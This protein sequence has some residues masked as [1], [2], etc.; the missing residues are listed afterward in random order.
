MSTVGPSNHNGLNIDPTNLY[1]ANLSLDFSQQELEQYFGEYG[2][3]VGSRVL[4]DKVTGASRGVAFVRF[5]NPESAKAAMTALNGT[6]A[7]RADRPL[8]V[9]N[10]QK[11]SGHGHKSAQHYDAFAAVPGNAMP[12]PQ[13]AL[14]NP[15]GAPAQPQQ[16]QYA[17][18]YADPFQQ[19]QP[20]YSTP[21]HQPGMSLTNCYI[22]GLPVEYGQ[23]ELNVLFAPYG[24]IIGSRVLMNNETSESRGIAFV[25]LD[26]HANATRAIQALNG[27]VIFFGQAPV[28]VTYAKE[29]EN[30]KGAKAVPGFAAPAYAPV[31][32]ETA[33]ARYAPYA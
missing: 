24:K 5:D 28:T 13:A 1:I 6:V 15:Y 10:A 27:S 4:S 9:K 7:P 29:R 17:D 14:Y 19:A 12:N 8:V 16:G 18:P 30:E 31:R 3:I 33:T 25:R 23:T 32:T 21:V 26:S 22:M 11:S 20:A 2:K